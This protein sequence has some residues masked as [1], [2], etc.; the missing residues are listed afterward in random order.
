MN[1]LSLFF[2][3]ILVQLCVLQISF[4]LVQCEEVE[5]QCSQKCCGDSREEAEDCHQKCAHA[6]DCQNLEHCF[7]IHHPCASSNHSNTKVT[8]P[9]ISTIKPSL[10]PV[11]EHTS[12][13]ITEP[14][15]EPT[16]NTDSSSKDADLVG[17][18]A[19]T[20][21]STVGGVKSLDDEISIIPS[22][23][24][25]STVLSILFILLLVS[26]AV[27][28]YIIVLRR[29]KVKVSESSTFRLGSEDFEDDLEDNLP[30]LERDAKVNI[31]YL[32]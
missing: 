15:L 14:K 12:I 19:N 18:N 2:S 13:P 8:P 22:T 23:T 20:N 16:K 11:S 3:F 17:K 31:R 26:V 27:F 28:T 5:K 32:Y 4:H 29:G 30:L 6:L 1:I 21:E 25:H 9:Q 24:D 7:I 10:S